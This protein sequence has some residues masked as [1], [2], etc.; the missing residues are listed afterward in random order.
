M[1]KIQWDWTQVITTLWSPLPTNY[2]NYIFFGTMVTWIFFFFYFYTDIRVDSNKYPQYMFLRVNKERKDF[3]QTLESARN[4]FT[5]FYWTILNFILLIPS[6]STKR[7]EQRWISCKKR[8]WVSDRR[9]VWGWGVGGRVEQY[10]ST[11]VADRFKSRTKNFH[12]LSCCCILGFL[13]QP[14]LFYGRI[15]GDKCCRYNEVLLSLSLYIYI[16]IYIY[17]ALVE[18]LS[19]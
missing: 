4:L 18:R 9:C 1:N 14:I 5:E 7:G 10:L 12:H 19:V 16:Y 17:N 13:K 3:C 6:E 2:I 15:L 11:E 8:L